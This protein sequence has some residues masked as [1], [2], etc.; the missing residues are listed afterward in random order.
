MNQAIR[1]LQLHAGDLR[2]AVQALGEVHGHAAS[3]DAA[4]DFLSDP[5]CLLFV[6]EEAGR[7]I[8]SLYGYAL[9]YPHRTQPQYLI[10]ELDVREECR[11]RG[12]GKALIQAF[13]DAARL[14]GAC[15]A[16]VISNDSNKSAMHAYQACGL[17]RVN[18][19]DAMLEINF[20]VARLENR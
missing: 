1:I 3:E 6:A 14:N 10:Y 2:L 7:P 9:R 19:D 13:L 8:G 16:W 17:R 4:K 20:S 18:S 12:I 15:E 11:N 5:H